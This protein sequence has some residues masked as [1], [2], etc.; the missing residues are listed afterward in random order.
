MSTDVWGRVGVAGGPEVDLDGL[1][2]LE[3][4]VGWM[5]APSVLG[6]ETGESHVPLLFAP[7]LLRMMMLGWVAAAVRS[8]A[9]GW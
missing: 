3:R 6:P 5:T 4:A 7:Q 1:D 9:A 8:P 2:V